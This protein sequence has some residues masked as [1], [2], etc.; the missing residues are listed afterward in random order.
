MSDIRKV[1][2]IGAGAVGSVFASR[3]YETPGFST[4]LIARDE[5]LEKLKRDGIQINGKLFH[6]PACRPDEAQGPVDLIL[7]AVKHHQLEEALRGLDPL[8]GE[9]TLFL[10]L[11]NG[12]ESEE[13]IAAR[14]GT[15][16]VLPA[17]SLQ[18]DAVRSGNQVS[19]TRPGIII[20]GEADNTTL[21]P[22]VRRVQAALERA[23]I[24]QRTPENMLRMLWWKFMVNV[25]VN[26][27]SAV[28][29]APYG[30]FQTNRDAQALMEALM[31]EAVALA[32]LEGI[33][34][35]LQDIQDWYPVMNTL[36]PEGKTSMLQDIE[37]GRQT[38]VEIFG[39]K[40]IALGEKHGLP[41][42]VNETVTRIIR[43]MEQS[44]PGG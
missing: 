7:V 37:A 13:T 25:G 2:I 44:A 26:Q 5:R 22:R 19:Y 9:E 32:Q 21:S 27:A 24:S 42:P 33:P 29:R 14:Y 8:V 23:G 20:F 10:S 28:L 40:V 17:I 43:V 38:E 36:S 30:V 18:I 15:D 4:L 35:T 3:F 11:M 39:G 1:A 6:I 31:R 41:T 12:L 34:L 16:S